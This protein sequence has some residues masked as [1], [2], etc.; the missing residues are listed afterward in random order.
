[1]Y[2][3]YVVFLAAVWTSGCGDKSGRSD[4]QGA[5]TF[6]GQPIP[7]GE[8]RFEPDAAK[9]GK[10]AQGVATIKN[11]RYTTNDGFGVVSGPTILRVTGFDGKKP[12]GP[13]AE[14][15]PDGRQLFSTYVSSID[16]PP[17][18]KKLDIDVPAKK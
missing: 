11:G 15:N 7:A 2:L 4:I 6:G 16:I 14:M 8:I 3:R 10:G 17:G 12:D 18:T 13:D 1:M 5:A 9:G